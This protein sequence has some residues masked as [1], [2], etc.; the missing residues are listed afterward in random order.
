MKTLLCLMLVGCAALTPQ[1]QSELSK[2]G[3]AILCVI[4]HIELDDANL[5]KACDDLMKYL[6]PAQQASV[7]E[8]AKS[9]VIKKTQQQECSK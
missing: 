9:I 2:T 3:A 8:A 6:T 1:E 7:R 5:N 4:E